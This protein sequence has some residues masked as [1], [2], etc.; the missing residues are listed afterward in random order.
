MNLIDGNTARTYRRRQ[1]V[2]RKSGYSIYVYS[3]NN[4]RIMM[5]TFPRSLRPRINSLGLS[6]V[7]MLPRAPRHAGT[8]FANHRIVLPL[9][10]TLISTGVQRVKRAVFTSCIFRGGSLKYGYCQYDH[11]LYGSFL[12]MHISCRYS[13][14]NYLCRKMRRNFQ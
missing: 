5:W 13:P 3:L 14:Q 12:P 11:I 2:G 1:R 6:L 4:E 7:A 9:K 8:V 10:F